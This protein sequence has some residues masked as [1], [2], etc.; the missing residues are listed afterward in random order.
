MHAELATCASTGYH[1]TQMESIWFPQLMIALHAAWTSRMG[2]SNLPLNWRQM[3]QEPVWQLL[4]GKPAMDHFFRSADKRPC[5]SNRQALQWSRQ[6]GPE[7]LSLNKIN[8]RVRGT[9][10]GRDATLVQI[11]RKCDPHS[12]KI[13]KQTCTLNQPLKL[14]ML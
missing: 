13:R 5:S 2:I 9:D 6:S 4:K 3:P 12:L 14:D 8:G 10:A 11:N 1:F 7:F